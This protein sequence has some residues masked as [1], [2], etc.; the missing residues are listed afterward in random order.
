MNNSNNAREYPLPQ[1]WN[2]AILR[3]PHRQT[4]M[5]LLRTFGI[6]LSLSQIL[7]LTCISCESHCDLDLELLCYLSSRWQG[8]Y[9]V[10]LFQLLRSRNDSKIPYTLSTVGSDAIHNHEYSFVA[11]LKSLM[12]FWWHVHSLTLLLFYL[13]DSL[14]FRIQ[15]GW[16]FILNT[17]ENLY[18]STFI[19]EINYMKCWYSC[20]NL[21]T[22]CFF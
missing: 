2:F 18:Y 11:F 21:I 17:H 14:G 8:I 19:N 3:F 15:S 7:L 20:L 16:W 9:R 5:E 13:H 22:L 4:S 10:L 12:I 1:A 6:W